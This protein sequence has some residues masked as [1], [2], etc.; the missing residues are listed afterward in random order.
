MKAL[1]L[2]LLSNVCLAQI[3]LDMWVTRIPAN[4]DGTSKTQEENVLIISPDK[5]KLGVVTRY[6]T[7]AL[8]YIPNDR[9]DPICQDKISGQVYMVQ[10]V[11]H[12]MGFTFFI[13]PIQ[14]YRKE[15]LYT[16]ILKSL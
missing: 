9:M 15:L 6:D 12:E 2:I 16:I 7:L 8:V 1:L 4:F 3:K 5:Y 13:S 14:P 11:F 10:T